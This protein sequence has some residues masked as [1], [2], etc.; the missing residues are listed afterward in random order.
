MKNSLMLTVVMFAAATVVAPNNFQSSLN[1]AELTL[2]TWTNSDG[3]SSAFKVLAI[4]GADVVDTVGGSAKGDLQAIYYFGRDCLTGFG[5]CPPDGV[6][7]DGA[8]FTEYSGSRWP[9]V[10]VTGDLTVDPE[11]TAD[12]ELVAF[13]DGVNSGNLLTV[14]GYAMYQF[15]FNPDSTASG[16]VFANA[17][18]PAWPLVKSNGDQVLL[19]P[20]PSSIFLLGSGLMAFGMIRRRRAT[21]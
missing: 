11:I 1:A 13:D 14:N 7:N 16:G 10:Y 15:A 8:A 21:R 2:E 4:T 6:V 12:I 9:L 18:G 20:E 19:I 17:V 3:E 5:Q